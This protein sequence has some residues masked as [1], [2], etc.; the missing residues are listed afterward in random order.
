MEENKKKAQHCLDPTLFLS[1]YPF[2]LTGTT[3]WKKRDDGQ[4]GGA[5]RNGDSQHLK[6]KE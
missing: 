1:L 3:R 4:K 5:Q 6:G 2:T